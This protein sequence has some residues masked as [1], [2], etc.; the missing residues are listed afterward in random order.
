MRLL[1]LL[2]IFIGLNSTLAQSSFVLN[3]KI[4]D[5][6]E[7]SV[8]VQINRSYLLYK[9]E[10]TTV[11]LASGQF[12]FTLNLERNRIVELTYGSMKM[13]VY[14]EPGKALSIEF[15][16][17]IPVQMQINGSVAE[18]N[19]MVQKFFTLFQADFND[20]LIQARALS[21]TIDAFEM[22]AFKQR[23]TQSEFLKNAPQKDKLSPDFVLF[24][25]DQI[26][27]HYWRQILA[28]PILNAN[29]D[30]KI[31]TVSP[32]PAVM[33]EGLEKVNVSNEKALVSDAYRE[34]LK[35]Y[36]TYF[37]SKANGFNKFKDPSTSADRKQAVAKEKLN[38]QVYAYWL[39]RF[40]TDECER[41]SPFIMK[42]MMAEL[43]E[44]DAAN[45]YTPSVKAH[46]DGRTGI[47]LTQQAEPV[48]EA[49]ESSKA[50]DDGLDLTDVNGKSVK[51]SDF[52]GKVV[53]IDFW[54]SWCG[55]CR[56]MM[57]FSKEL[58]EKLTDKE[59]KQII[60][61]YISIDANKDGWLKGIKD[62]DI[63]GVNVLS[64]GNWS[65]KAC[66]YFQIN[67]IPRYMIMNKK[68]D[69]V[70]F[71]APRPVEPTLI[72]ELRRYAAE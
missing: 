63:Q 40:T 24:L 70:N 2:F 60:F 20:S 15:T 56:G 9:P 28:Y 14:A 61:L 54:A 71:N 27:Y 55:P 46:C 65:S 67:S 37:A 11:P 21:S 3:G 68:G 36:V 34:F 62:M 50:S 31:L 22:E 16:D 13:P 48:K 66:S 44:N 49:K 58:H 41:M 17:A 18:E 12:S 32:L 23:K 5:A 53:Y 35:Y 43:K 45:I 51:L 26:N 72:E 69:I 39:A 4:T 57:P 8:Q 59:K 33:L 64:P 38:G 42:K 19:G 29:K 10:I 47:S 1:T 30:Q 25:Q 52:K 6:K 7:K